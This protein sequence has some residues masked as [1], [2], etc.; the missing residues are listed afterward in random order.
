MTLTDA[1]FLFLAGAAASGINSI[2]GGGTLVTFPFLTFGM[3]LPVNVANATNSVALWPGSLGGV[4]GLWN[5]YPKVRTQLLRLILPT[6]VGSTFGAWL[7]IAAGGDTFKRVVPYLILLAAVLLLF[8]PRIKQWVLG[9][10]PHV[11][12]WVGML[13]QFWVAV[14]G[15]Y[16]GAGMGIMMLAVFAL[17]I[18]ANTH[19]IN[20]IKNS[21]GVVINLSASALFFVSGLV[22]IEILIPL[23]IGGVVGG[24]GVASWSQKI[25]PDKLRMAVAVYGV[26]MA[27]LYFVR[28]V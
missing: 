3:H 19:E 11:P 25:P 21:M 16:F 27:G 23:A 12:I 24:Y 26:L 7:F 2:A 20:L 4:F 10:R 5:L 1:A 22:N 13:L 15:G 17:F 28:S 9:E 14:Y 18:D 6:A 8:Q